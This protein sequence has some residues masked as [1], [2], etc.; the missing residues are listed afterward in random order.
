MKLVLSSGTSFM[1][2]LYDSDTKISWVLWDVIGGAAPIVRRVTTADHGTTAQIEAVST[3]AMQQRAGP[4]TL[5]R[6]LDV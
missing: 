4:W 3:S 5:V 1:T 2:M 6:S